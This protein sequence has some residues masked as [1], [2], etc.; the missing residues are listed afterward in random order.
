MLLV[1]ITIAII[2]VW[3]VTETV[4]WRG[5]CKIVAIGIL[6]TKTIIWW[7]FNCQITVMINWMIIVIIDET[8]WFLPDIKIK[9][10]FLVEASFDL[11]LTSQW[12]CDLIFIALPFIQPYKKGK[13][14]KLLS[15]IHIKKKI[16]ILGKKNLKNGFPKY[17][18][19]DLL[20]STITR[21]DISNYKGE[22]KK[23]R[24]FLINHS[25]INDFF[26]YLMR[27]QEE[28]GYCGRGRAG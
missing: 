10:S 1:T 25:L 5:A 4:D 9:Y 8:N 6:D 24:T 15:L 28:W 17:R 22:N 7:I 23:T 16:L 20:P 19:I 18:P 21:V 27:Y 2:T 12:V 26:R 11:K 14:A 13:K 3:N